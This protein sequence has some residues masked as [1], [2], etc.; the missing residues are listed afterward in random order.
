[1]RLWIA[2]SLTLALAGAARAQDAPPP[3]PQLDDLERRLAEQQAEM[4]RMQDELRQLRGGA[5]EPAGTGEPGPSTEQTPQEGA[6]GA[7]P[8]GAAGEEPTAE[9]PTVTAAEPI[10]LGLFFIESG[11]GKHRLEI[12]ARLQVDGRFVADHEHDDF[13]NSFIVR[14]GRVEFGGKLYEKVTFKLQLEFGRTSDADFRDAWL[15][16][17]V[18]EW[19]QLRAGQMLP[20]FSTERLI[21]SKYMRFPERPIII[22]N[23]ADPRE[24]GLMVHGHVSKKLFAYYLGVYNGNGQN[25][26]RDN[27]DDK[28]LAAR[29]E[30]KPLDALMLAASYRY[31]PTNRE[32][33]AGPT[34]VETVGNQITKFL[35]YAGTNSGLG[36]RERGTLDA[37][38]RAGSIE[39][40]SEL[41]W[42]Y[43][44]K[45]VSAA[46][47]GADL[48]N[49]GWYVDTCFVATGEKQEDSIDP[50]SPFWTADGGHGTGAFELCLRYE[51]FHADRQTIRGGFATGTNVA[52]SVTPAISWIPVRHVRVIL[53]YTYT[54]YE[55]VVVV[56]GRREDDDHVIVTRLAFDW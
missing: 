32:D 43:H 55:D 52:R 21:S 23:I 36:P 25:V 17:E 4:Q 16:L 10:K 19:L 1:M 13:D 12:G 51:E 56:A 53:S 38:V 20:P 49:W 26:A 5:V 39:V 40:R 44:R 18:T 47:E 42:D 6:A 28:D 7:G 9:G 48:L 34:D 2:F 41:V 27:D 15:N 14:R 11:D 8:S 24:I 35:D 29:I 37:R 31:T 30:V 22:G 45:V 3:T 33:D 50:A 54:D 46:G